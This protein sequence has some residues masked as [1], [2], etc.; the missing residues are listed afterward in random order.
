MGHSNSLSALQQGDVQ[1][2]LND[3]D[4]QGQ[5]LLRGQGAT[6]RELIAKARS[7]IA[8]LETPA[9]AV[10]WMAWAEVCK[11]LS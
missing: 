10:T 2:L 8:Y 5:V 4:A 3:I 6:R 11:A 7:L 1:E 9:E